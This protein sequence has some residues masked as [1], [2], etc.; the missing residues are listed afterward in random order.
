MKDKQ[1]N[2]AVSNETSP[3]KGMAAV[4]THTEEETPVEELNKNKADSSAEEQA[5]EKAKSETAQGR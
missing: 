4:N 3:A 2:P 5:D 1:F